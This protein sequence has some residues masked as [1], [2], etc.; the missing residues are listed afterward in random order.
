MIE[1][2]ASVSESRSAQMYPTLDAVE[3]ARIAR[4]G[5][6]INYGDGEMLFQSGTPGAGLFVLLTGQVQVVRRDGLGHVAPVVLHD[7]GSFV[8]EVGQLTG[9]VALFDGCAV[10]NVS[11]LLVRP[12][13][14]RALLVAEASL[15]ER[16]MRALILRRVSI[17]ES[18]AGGPVLI[19]PLDSIDT[20]RLTGFLRRNGYPHQVV[21]PEQDPEAKSLVMQYESGCCEPPLVVCADGSILHNPS[22]SDLARHLG[23]LTKAEPG[24]VYDVVIVGA[25]PA[26]L[27]A[28][29]YAASEGLS[30]AVLDRRAF[31]GQA[32]ASARI[33]NYFGFPTGISGQALAARAYVQAQKFGVE[34]A[35]P[36]HAKTLDC[37]DKAGNGVNA[38]ELDD[39]SRICGK[40]VVIASGALYRRPDIPE[41]IRFEGRGVWYWASPV[42]AKLSANS[43][44]VIVGG[45]NS[46]GQAAVFL[47]ANAA[48]V[49][50]LVRGPN[51]ARGMSRY[52]VD[53]LQATENINI[54]FNS[55]VMALEGSARWL[56][57]VICVNRE[58]NDQ[59]TL[60]TSNLFLFVG[61][62]PETD[63]LRECG[64]ELDQSG[65]VVTGRATDPDGH[66]DLSLQSSRAGVFAVGD[67]RAGSVKRMG[68]A[69]GEG[70]TVVT[71]IHRYLGRPARR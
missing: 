37:S 38:V 31:G 43:L 71:Q 14:L 40:A 58:S 36:V 61:A 50:M 8:A 25:G 48:R 55:E 27:A 41:L 62:D 49:E 57:R 13:Q 26:G 7:P 59:R 56:E 47:S 64:A 1:V 29:V 23:M 51:L 9:R 2:L 4:F 60:L 28:A 18:G 16:I 21:D 63:W 44:V 45:G 15:G 19:G 42:E 11:T 3:I 20:V 52:L 66:G 22:E 10:G 6:P 24:K 46:A 17:I 70:A 32:G 68:G 53:R 33:E 34:F 5:E 54:T 30:V 12:E 69:I 65:F 35:I 67:V 39:G